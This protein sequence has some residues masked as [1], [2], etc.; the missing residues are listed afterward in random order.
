MTNAEYMRKYRQRLKDR[1]EI[2]KKLRYTVTIR[3]LQS[4][5]EIKFKNI[6][7]DMALWIKQKLSTEMVDIKITVDN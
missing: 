2:E 1:K 3:L 7:I 6:E 5:N 4:H